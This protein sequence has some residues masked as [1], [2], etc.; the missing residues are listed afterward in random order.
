MEPLRTELRKF[1]KS[2][3]RPDAYV[4]PE[5]K[6]A[7]IDKY[8]KKEGLRRKGILYSER[9]N[10][11]NKERIEALRKKKEEVGSDYKI[12]HNERYELRKQ[13]AE[14]IA[15]RE[16][17]RKVLLLNDIMLSTE[18]SLERKLKQIIDGERVFNLNLDLKNSVVDPYNF[19]LT[20]LTNLT[21]P[22]DLQKNRMN[23]DNFKKPFT[24]VNL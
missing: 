20:Q 8:G 21:H 1:P 13:E 9:Y 12:D 16:E 18:R 4:T 6:Q 24:I 3:P 23:T 10:L 2:K 22:T 19:Y 11:V 5:E 17:I 7:L 14:F 15:P